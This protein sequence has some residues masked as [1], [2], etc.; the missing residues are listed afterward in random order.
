MATRDYDFI[1]ITFDGKHSIDDFG[2]YRTSD[3]N[4]YNEN[5]IPPFND[6]TA[7]I[8]GGDGQY[9]FYTLHKPR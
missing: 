2:I 4:R 9:Y 3:G 6:K 8:P 1:G 5:I 7:D